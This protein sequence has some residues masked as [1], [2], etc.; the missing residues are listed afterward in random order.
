MLSGIII[1]KEKDRG[2]ILWM[3]TQVWLTWGLSDL[4]KQWHVVF[5]MWH[6][7]FEIEKLWLSGWIVIKECCSELKDGSNGE[8]CESKMREKRK[9][10]RLN[11]LWEVREKRLSWNGGLS[12]LS[13]KELKIVIYLLDWEK[14]EKVCWDWDGY[15]ESDLKGLERVHLEKW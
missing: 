10:R 5:Q 1:K 6:K 2:L 12:E 13:W 9:K 4:A 7:G 8:I 3:T 14:R 11:W 15:K